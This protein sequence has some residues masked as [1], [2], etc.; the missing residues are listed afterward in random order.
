MKLTKLF[1]LL[2]ASA[3]LL[4]G[5]GGDDDR[6]VKPT[7]DITLKADVES[8]VVGQSITFTVTDLEGTDVTASATIFNRTDNYAEVSNP[9]VATKEGRNEFFAVVGNSSSDVI[10]VVVAPEIAAL[11]NDPQPDNTSFAHHILL[12]DHTGVQCGQ[13][14]RMMSALRQ[15]SET[16]GYHEKYF[17]VMA[18][19]YNTNDPAYSKAAATV[20]SHFSSFI[21]TSGYPTLTYNFFY[22]RYSTAD[23]E[24]IKQTIDNLWSADGADAGIAA[25]TIISASTA[26][27]NAEVKAAVTAEYYLTAWLLEDNIYARQAGRQEEWQDYHHNAIRNMP[28]GTPI[29]GESLGVIEAGATVGKEF[30]LPITS[31]DWAVD[32]MRVVLIVSAKTD[33]SGNAIDVVNVVS[34]PGNDS[35]AYEYLN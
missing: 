29:Y 25:S 21:V 17:E 32:N 5:C 4:V 26:S 13:C 31:P 1:A 19:S 33:D 20:S 35:V 2:V 30:Y 12:I 3:T 23:A 6:E 18:H 16:E 9:Y 27:V 15:V 14:P 28:A 7:G 34:C 10:E 22:N 8:V 24:D 11:P